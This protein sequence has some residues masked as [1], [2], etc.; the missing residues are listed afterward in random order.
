M[1]V[2]STV[3]GNVAASCS[4][5]ATDWANDHLQPAGAGL[6]SR[7]NLCIRLLSFRVSVL[8]VLR[9]PLHLWPEFWIRIWIRVSFTHHSKPALCRGTLYCRPACRAVCIIQAI[10]RRFQ[11]QRYG[12]RTRRT[13]I[14]PVNHTQP[15]SS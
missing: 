10:C 3:N 15:E 7:T 8:S 14:N 12:V 5:A 4:A 13:E 11:T 1:G 6:R 9:L 2:L